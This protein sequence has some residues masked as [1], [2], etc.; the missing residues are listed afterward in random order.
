M[1]ERIKIAAHSSGRKPED[2]KLVVVSK[3]QSLDAMR[4]LYDA[5]VRDFG[6]SRIQEAQE[7]LRALPSDIHWHMIG[8]LQ[9][10]KVR[11][12]VGS[13]DLIHSVDSLHLA[14]KINAVSCELG[15]TARI[16]LEVNT[17]KEVAKHGMIGDE[18]LQKFPSFLALKNIALCGLMTMAPR[19]VTFDADE[20]KVVRGCFS[21]LCQLKDKLCAKYPEIK[22]SLTEL[23]MGMSQDFEIAIQEGAT[24]VRIGS[25]IFE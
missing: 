2:V 22:N 8:S 5:G 12:V 10:N 7:K 14:E 6:E 13:C 23:S 24:L 18:L 20:L 25:L 3:G 19:C 21:E 16:L 9:T 15:I 4:A 1:Q 11:K 17:S